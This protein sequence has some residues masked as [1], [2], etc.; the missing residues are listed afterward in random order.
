MSP[1]YALYLITK[2]SSILIVLTVIMM[3]INYGI[4]LIAQWRTKTKKA[5]NFKEYFLSTIFVAYLSAL[6]MITLARQASLYSSVNLKLFQ[7]Y[8]TS[9]AVLDTRS[10]VHI[11][12]NILMTIP[13][14]LLLPLVYKKSQ[15]FLNFLV[16]IVITIVSIESLQMI[17]GRGIFDIDDIFNNLL[18]GIIGFGFTN[19]YL[20]F[21]QR[22]LT[23][24]KFLLSLSPL[25]LSVIVGVTLFLNYQMQ[26]FGNLRIHAEESTKLKG[27]TIS[28]SPNLDLNSTTIK[29]KGEPVD[30]TSVDIFKR[31][32]PESI[33]MQTFFNTLSQYDAI[34]SSD[35][36]YP[37]SDEIQYSYKD[38]YLLFNKRNGNI[39]YSRSTNSEYST[40]TDLDRVVDD[41]GSLN[42]PILKTQ[43]HHSEIILEKDTWYLAKKKSITGNLMYDGTAT[44]RYDQSDKIVVL[45]YG[46]GIFEKVSTV[47]LISP[48]EIYKSIKKG[49]FPTYYYTDVKEIE[50][51]SIELDYM[52]DS[53]N[54]MQPIYKVGL[55]FDGNLDY[56]LLPAIKK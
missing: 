5:F 50:M 17:L 12:M 15:K 4:H 25:I 7:S 44:I 53:K 2:V 31:I 32:K 21:K 41:L 49:K 39:R 47:D 38:A 11:V 34:E 37:N 22:N 10:L 9:I 36:Y 24:P 33:D 19:N 27:K 14:G 16:I 30:I 26:P 29:L 48:E 1:S 28:I 46:I 51:I 56:V 20:N 52:E 13:F 55:T 8:R 35:W 43:I 3:G 54:F 45:D 42:L 40:S 23:L 6:L 18:G